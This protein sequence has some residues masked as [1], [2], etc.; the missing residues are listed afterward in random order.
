[1]GIETSKP[2]ESFRSF[3][4]V[5][6]EYIEQLTSSYM[7][8]AWFILDKINFLDLSEENCKTICS[9]FRFSN[10]NEELRKYFKKKWVSIYLHP[11]YPNSMAYVLEFEDL[12]FLELNWHTFLKNTLTSNNKNRYLR[13][14]IYEGKNNL[15]LQ[16]QDWFYY[17]LEYVLIE[18]LRWWLQLDYLVLKNNRWLNDIIDIKR[19]HIHELSALYFIQSPAWILRAIISESP[20]VYIDFDGEELTSP[21]EE[22][23]HYPMIW[24][25]EGTLKAETTSH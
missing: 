9:L 21:M 10:G 13:P 25:T 15:I 20:K 14:F 12:I 7:R 1:M 17:F 11:L 23:D 3:E 2:N 19:M 22:K 18:K 24:E 4:E 6:A 8:K 16:V 5:T